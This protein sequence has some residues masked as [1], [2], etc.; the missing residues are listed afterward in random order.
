MQQVQAG[1]IVQAQRAAARQSI[2]VEL[3]PPQAIRLE[4]IATA[5]LERLK[6]PPRV[7]QQPRERAAQ[8]RR[9]EFAG[10]GGEHVDADRMQ[11]IGSL[12]ELPQGLAHLVEQLAV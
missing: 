8:L 3:D 2:V 4:W 5:L 12:G 1:A 7:V 6:P 11:E 10:F 9:R